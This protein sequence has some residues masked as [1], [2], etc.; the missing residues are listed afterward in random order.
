MMRLTSRPAMRPASLVA[1]RWESL[2]YAGTV[3]TASVT[4]SPRKA[5]AVFFIFSSTLAETSCGASFLPSASA[6]QASPFSCW[7]IAY[8]TRPRSFCTSASVNLRPIRRFTAWKVFLGL[9]T[10]WRLA[11]AP[12]R[13]SPSL[14]QATTDGVVRSPSLFSMTRALP[15]SMTATHE[16][17]VPRSRPMILPTAGSW[18]ALCVGARCADAGGVGAV[19]RASSAFAASAAPTRGLFGDHDQGRAQQAF[20]QDVTLLE[21]LRHRARG[22][23]LGRGHAHGLVALRVEGLAR[24][25]RDLGQAV[26]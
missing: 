6:T 7:V 11:E 26:G 25:R 15:P 12:T 9:V 2:K 19:G 17:V 18:L 10:A 23:A 8:G 14:V 21:Q 24:G 20:V 3:I 16:L 1:W 13:T 5:S 22:N 4:V